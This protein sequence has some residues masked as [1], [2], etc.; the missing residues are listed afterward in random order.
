MGASSVRRR[1]KHFKDGKVMGTLFWDS[2]GGILG[3]F[4]EKAETIN[5]AR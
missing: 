1:M 5:A 2:E 3:D 4:L